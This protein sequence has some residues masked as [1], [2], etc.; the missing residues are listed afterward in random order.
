MASRSGGIRFPLRATSI[1][2]NNN[3]PPSKP[4]I[5]RKLITASEIDNVAV[6]DNNTVSLDAS[7]ISAVATSPDS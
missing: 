5:G 1:S 6:S 7:G 3:L 4:G 2:T